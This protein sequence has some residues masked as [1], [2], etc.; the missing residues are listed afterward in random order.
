MH[1][2]SFDDHRDYTVLWR[3]PD[4]EAVLRSLALSALA[5]DRGELFGESILT[6]LLRIPRDPDDQTSIAEKQ[7]R[8]LTALVQDMAND[9]SRCRRLFYAISSLSTSR[10]VALVRTYLNLE[11]TLEAFATLRLE[12][13][14]WGW[15][16]SEV[17][18]LETRRSFNLALLPLFDRP[19]LVAHRAIIEE[20]LR[21]LDSQIM[22]AK[23]TDFL[24]QRD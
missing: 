8:L 7:D 17:P 1:H 15:S 3:R 16:G 20:R 13:M 24:E 18:V 9:D 2:P 4:W 23:R 22:R 21:G 12:P 6:T 14:M 11:P 5:S 19:S 10:R